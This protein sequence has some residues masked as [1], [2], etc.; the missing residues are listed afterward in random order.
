MIDVSGGFINGQID[1]NWDEAHIGIPI[2]GTMSAPDVIAAITNGQKRAEFTQRQIFR[3][4]LTFSVAGVLAVKE[5]AMR[6]LNVQINA[7]RK[8]SAEKLEAARAA[9]QAAQYAIAKNA[10]L[11]GILVH[12]NIPRSTYDADPA[13][14]A[15]IAPFVEI[16]FDYKKEVI[17]AAIDG[18]I[19]EKQEEIEKQIEAA[20]REAIHRQET[21]QLRETFER[22]IVT[23]GNVSDKN[24]IFFYFQAGKGNLRAVPE[25]TNG[26]TAV[27]NAKLM[28]DAVE[29]LAGYQLTTYVKAALVK[30]LSENTSLEIGLAGV[31]AR[32]YEIP[33]ITGA[34]YF[35]QN[36]MLSKSEFDASEKIFSLD[37][38]MLQTILRS[39]PNE[40]FATL[41][42]GPSTKISIGSKIRL[43]SDKTYLH[44]LLLSANTSVMKDHS[45][46]LGRVLLE[47][48]ISDRLKLTAGGGVTAVSVDGTSNVRACPNGEV[49]GSYAFTDKL[50]GYVNL[51]MSCE[52]KV[53]FTGLRFIFR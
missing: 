53:I 14:R 36:M 3:I 23:I 9:A 30:V 19:R 7:A 20:K 16:I 48:A 17:D 35:M 51:A 45:K 11:G 29:Q 12:S 6:E 41:F 49:G 21:L 46:L 5:V 47:Q 22:F 32:G 4:D 26:R 8:M 43:G 13:L 28:N 24:R 40:F 27:Q 50:T 39:G 38:V 31:Q 1:Y 52:D 33:F 15:V 37:T 44:L 34:Q 25:N 2:I 10:I 42:K 18:K